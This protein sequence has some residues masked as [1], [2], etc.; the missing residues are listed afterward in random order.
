VI[1]VHAPVWKVW[2]EEMRLVPQADSG[3]STHDSPATR[4]PQ[5]LVASLSQTELTRGSNLVEAAAQEAAAGE[6]PR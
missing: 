2:T 1:D 4:P 6:R 5:G 3:R